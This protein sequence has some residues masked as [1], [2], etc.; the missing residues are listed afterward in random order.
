MR[1]NQNNIPFFK[2][3]HTAPIETT[4]NIFDDLMVKIDKQLWGGGE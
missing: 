1:Y 2:F 3:V 4:C